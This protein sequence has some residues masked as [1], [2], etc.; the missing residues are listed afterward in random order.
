MKG[1]L[2]LFDN[3]MKELKR[4]SLLKLPLKKEYIEKRSQDMYGE[5]DP[6]IIYETAIINR[7]GLELLEE[8]KDRDDICDVH[9]L[10][11]LSDVLKGAVNLPA[12]AKYGRFE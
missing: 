12:E 11:V 1:F 4:T 2:I 3:N 7:F 9:G 10:S 6:C 8:I 5:T